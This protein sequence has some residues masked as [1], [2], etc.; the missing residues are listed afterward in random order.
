MM[1]PTA[2]SAGDSTRAGGASAR[3]AA[4]TRARGALALV[5]AVPLSIGAAIFIVRVAPRLRLAGVI[6]FLVEFLAAI[7]SIAYGIWGLF[8]L[9]P[10]LQVKV[11]PGVQALLGDVPG[12][13]WLFRET[14]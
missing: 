14:V 12:L 9:A 7:P 10:F 1:Q 2:S 13:R 5:F 11:E 4:R 3:P 8:V 6:S